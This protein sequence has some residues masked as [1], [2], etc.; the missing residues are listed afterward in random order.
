MDA[1]C[2]RLLLTPC[3]GGIRVG[4]ITVRIAIMGCIALLWVCCR[5]APAQGFERPFLLHPPF[6]V[7]TTAEPEALFQRRQAD[8]AKGAEALAAM[9]LPGGRTNTENAT[10]YAILTDA[11]RVFEANGNEQ[12]RAVAIG[13]LEAATDEWYSLP[14]TELRSRIDTEGAFNKS[15]IEMKEHCFDLALRYHLTQDQQ[16]A[17]QAAIILDQYN[18]VIRQWPLRGRDDERYAQDDL[19]FK[20]RWDTRGLY[21]AWFYGMTARG[22]PLVYA[23]DLIYPSG[24]MEQLGV[25]DSAE[26]LLRYHIEFRE[27]YTPPTYG[28]LDDYDMRAYPQY[29]RLL[30]EPEFM[31]L[32]AQ[33]LD[34][35]LHYGYYADG[36]WQ[37][38]SCSYHKDLTVGLTTTVPA[39]MKGYSDP[40][41]FV[42]EIDGTRFDNLDITR[43]HYTQFDRMW[44]SLGALTFPTRHCVVVHDTTFVQQAWWM[45]QVTH[46][47][48]RLLGCMGHAVLGK[49]EG[50]NQQQVHL[51]FSG[52]HGHEHG[53]SLALIVW[54]QN[55]EMHSGTSYRE[56]PGD[57]SSRE[58]H[59]AT[60]GHNTVVI[61][62]T[63]QHTRFS[64]PR[65]TITEKDHFPFD[66]QPRW[67]NYGHGDSMTDGRLRLYAAQWAPVQIA[68]ADGDRAYAGLAQLYRRTI[69]LVEVDTEHHYIVDVFRVRGGETH[70][71]M[72]HGCLQ[73]P[74]TLETDVALSPRPGSMHKFIDELQ[75]GAVD[76]GDSFSFV[77][78]D[79]KRSRHW[80]LM[81][82]A[83]ELW[84]GRGPA[85][86]RMGYNPFAF[87]RHQGAESLFVAVHEFFAGESALAGVEPLQMIGAHPMDAGVQINL[88]DG[89]SDLFVSCFDPQA[90][91]AT[92][93]VGAGVPLKL[94]GGAVHVRLGA[95]GGVERLFAAGADEL[96]AADTRPAEI[97]SWHSGIVTQVLRKETGDDVDALVSDTPLPADGSLDGAAVILTYGD[98]L[99]QSFLIDRVTTEGAKT[100]I[101]LQQ[102]AGISI[103]GDGTMVKLHYFPG[104][105]IDGQCSFRIAGTVLAERVDGQVRVTGYP[106]STWPEPVEAGITYWKPKAE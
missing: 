54:S 56:I 101:V 63:S 17:R 27:S 4:E 55:E 50:Q 43:K 2:A 6:S 93:A 31:H 62:Q 105:G 24:A 73:L 83:S 95:D 53:D 40:P 69:A 57:V 77:Y 97:T 74:Y 71:W 45:P 36:F 80:L 26:A 103:E 88:A 79:G 100:L 89:R 76:A 33:W 61:D 68:E 11:I 35:L 85:M 67:H 87:V 7:I 19:E 13:M 30:P 3:K 90:E 104:W 16:A 51:H 98:D 5:P 92:M 75:A 65:R 44:R 64:G 21:G 52:M 48:P 25:R 18:Q 12:C 84:A 82:E 42:S 32:T 37:E 28:N 78:E 94:R 8:F 1:G 72:L 49:G 60:A 14:E 46:S 91:A 10:F 99:V 106:K 47:N 102:D 23:F 66:P 96:A 15:N 70:D 34:N 39:L 38:G 81:P 9:Y 86:R 22:L 20:Q 58:W 59:A 29:A 41:G